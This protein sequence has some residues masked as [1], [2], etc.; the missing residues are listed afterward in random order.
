MTKI[1]AKSR[2]YAAKGRFKLHQSVDSIWNI[3]N[4]LLSAN[5]GSASM[6]R[7]DDST[8][9]VSSM[10]ASYHTFQCIRVILQKASASFQKT[11]STPGQCTTDNSGSLLTIPFN[12]EASAVR[13][14]EF[15]KKLLTNNPYAKIESLKDAAGVSSISIRFL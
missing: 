7:L 15:G 5:D 6:L 8:K 14:F 1:N 12:D 9:L 2:L 13:A 11:S 4:S 3:E 10:A